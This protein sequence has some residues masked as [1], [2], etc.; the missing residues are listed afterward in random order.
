MP[1]S[2]ATQEAMREKGMRT[3]APILIRAFKKESE[4]EV[5]KQDSSG[6]MALLKT[7]PMCRWSGQLGPKTREGT[8]RCL[9]ASTAC[10]SRR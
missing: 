2:L 1:V 9:R 7:Y 4:L 6:K 3:H 10:R 8:V 5:W